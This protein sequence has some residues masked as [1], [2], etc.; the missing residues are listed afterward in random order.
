MQHVPAAT[1]R[2]RKV[3]SRNVRFVMH[4]GG[5]GRG[6]PRCDDEFVENNGLQKKIKNRNTNA[7]AKLLKMYLKKPPRLSRRARIY[8][9]Y[10]Y[11]PQKIL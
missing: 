4:G 3:A 9:F 10:I 1:R 7:F 8:I 6:D 5:V 2:D 11:T